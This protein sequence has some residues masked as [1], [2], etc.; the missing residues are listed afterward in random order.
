MSSDDRDYA[1]VG[2]VLGSEFRLLRLPRGWTALE[3]IVLAKC[4]DEEG[5]STWAFRET[6]AIHDEEIIGPLT[7][8][9]ELWK[10]RTIDQYLPRD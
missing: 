4:L 8:Q 2:E 7:V 3:G 5:N 6:E 10:A 1:P 9:L